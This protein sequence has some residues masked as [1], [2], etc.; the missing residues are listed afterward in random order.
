MLEKLAQWKN[1]EII[2]PCHRSNA[3][4][5]LESGEYATNTQVCGVMCIRSESRRC[6]PSWSTRTVLPA[7]TYT[8]ALHLSLAKLYFQTWSRNCSALLVL[9]DN[10]CIIDQGQ[11]GE[12]RDRVSHQTDQSG[13]LRLRGKTG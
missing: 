6:Q 2:G 5:K 3:R 10:N 9:I 12:R 11:V 4:A 1:V 8:V 7:D 13:G